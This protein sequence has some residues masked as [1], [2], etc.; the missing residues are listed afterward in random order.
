MV[1]DRLASRS[2][3]LL[4]AEVQAGRVPMSRID[5]AEPAHPDQEVRARPVRAP[6]R[7]PHLRRRT[8]GSAGAPGARPAGGARVAGAAEERRQRAAAG[9]D[10]RQDLRGRQDRR[11]HRQ[12]ERR[13]DDQLAGRAPA[14]PRPGT[15]ILQGIRRP[16]APAPTVTYSRDGA[17][18]D[19][20]YRRAIAVVGETP[21]RRG[22]RATGPARWAWT[23]TDLRPSRRCA[24]SGVPVIVVLVS[25]RPLDIA[26]Q[27]PDWTGAGGRLAARHRG[28]RA[29][30]TCCSATTRRPASCP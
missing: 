30:P 16:A 15:T 12:P 22:R 17:G 14:R 7:R 25:G 8:V 2:S 19:G 23:P 13:L 1:P 18:I 11:R 9:E 10:R 27:L 21:V 5:D 4:Q 26:A 29:S 24:P 28:R 20:S 3:A 6:A